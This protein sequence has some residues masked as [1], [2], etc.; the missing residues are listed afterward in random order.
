MDIGMINTKIK[1][2]LILS[3]LNCGCM[4]YKK[5]VNHYVVNNGSSLL[6]N[7]SPIKVSGSDAQD[8]LNGNDVKPE[9]SLPII[10]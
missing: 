3:I 1:A 9:V 4:T 7:G 5:V 10:P 6:I 8:S 2:L